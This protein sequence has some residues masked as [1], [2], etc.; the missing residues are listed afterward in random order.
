[1]KLYT[2]L[3]M[4][5]REEISRQLVTGASIRSIAGNLRRHASTIS[6]EIRRYGAIEHKYYRAIWGQGH[7]NKML[8]KQRANRKLET[9]PV[10]RQ[11][12]L[13]LLH[14]KWSPQQIAKRLKVLYPNDIT[15]NVSHETIYS[16]L[17]VLP[18]GSLKKDIVKC[19]RREHQYRQTKKPK[20]IK[21]S[22]AIQDYLSIEERPAE[23]ADRIIPGHWEG[24][25]LMGSRNASAIG[26][27]VERT[28][29]MTFLVKLE[30]KD[31]IAVRKAFAEEFRLLPPG[32]KRTLT[33]DQG[34]EMAQHKIFTQETNITVYFAHPH[35]PWERGTNENTNGLLRQYFP[36]GTDFKKISQERLKEVQDEFNDRP[37]KVL[38]WYTPHECFGK[39]LR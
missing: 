7:H 10:L 30:N 29:R 19:L 4:L 1:M 38:D 22:G 14:K 20:S 5:E 9:N 15:M 37:R 8:H 27:L 18:R 36:K 28:T 32:L 17:Y 3:T 12:V 25:L 21:T 34:Q 31:A 6:R 13:D 26:I 11:S 16:F 33:Y 39:L 23:V 2:R 24:D 35:S